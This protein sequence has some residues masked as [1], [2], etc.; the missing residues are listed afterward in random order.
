M[1]SKEIKRIEAEERRLA[2]EERGDLG[3][4]EKLIAG[5][6]GEGKEA[7]RLRSRLGSGS[8]SERE[9]GYVD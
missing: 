2:R 8:L 4:L 3:Q 9:G 1:K 5:G 7:Q 6:H